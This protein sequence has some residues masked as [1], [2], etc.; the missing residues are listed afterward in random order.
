MLLAGNHL[1]SK[2]SL[3]GRRSN[4]TRE[5]TERRTPDRSAKHDLREREE[6]ACKHSIIFA[7][8]VV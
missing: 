4:G 6:N 5:G 1:V 8:A 7:M 3:R 2:A